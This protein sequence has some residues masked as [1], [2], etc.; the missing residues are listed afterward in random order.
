MQHI[1][2]LLYYTVYNIIIHTY[3]HTLPG[4]Q[5]GV[6]NQEKEKG[7]SLSLVL[8][9]SHPLVQQEVAL[10][11]DLSHLGPSFSESFYSTLQNEASQANHRQMK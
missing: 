10:S 1:D 9:L 4:D 7:V 6:R 5:I 8:L 2:L 3:T 11:P